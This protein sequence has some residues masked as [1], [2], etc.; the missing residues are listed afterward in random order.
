MQ[1]DL[2]QYANHGLLK[3][4]PY[5]S[6]EASVL[7]D[8]L[9]SDSHLSDIVLFNTEI[10][11]M[12]RFVQFRY[13]GHLLTMSILTVERMYRLTEEGLKRNY[14]FRGDR[15]GTLVGSGTVNTVKRAPEHGTAS[16][17][18]TRGLVGDESTDPVFSPYADDRSQQPQQWRE[19]G[20]KPRVVL[21][22]Q[23]GALYHLLTELGSD[24][25]KVFR[26]PW[27]VL[28]RNHEFV[29]KLFEYVE[30]YAPA[31]LLDVPSALN[32]LS[33]LANDFDEGPGVINAHLYGLESP[34]HQSLMNFLPGELQRPFL[35]IVVLMSL[36]FRL[37]NPD[38]YRDI[39]HDWVEDRDDQ[40]DLNDRLVRACRRAVL[41]RS[42]AFNNNHSLKIRGGKAP[43]G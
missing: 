6:G 38:K 18:S 39:I 3:L 5:E 37:N 8:A 22:E 9:T 20:A 24:G 28:G 4:E 10:P 34:I 26:I 15:P 11:E 43:V 16:H 7:L 14:Y 40:D 33:R 13:N 19:L 21:D 31:Q 12:G 35:F 41:V 27:Q 36:S 1:V 30:K 42:N 25:Y 2:S 29:G 32:S 23:E 17:G